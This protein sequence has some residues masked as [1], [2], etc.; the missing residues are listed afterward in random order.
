[1]L[2][3]FSEFHSTKAISLD[4]TN[5]SIVRNDNWISE[6]DNLNITIKLVPKVII[7]DETTNIL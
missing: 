2:F 4:G 5:P 7:I 3:E 1:M 6:R